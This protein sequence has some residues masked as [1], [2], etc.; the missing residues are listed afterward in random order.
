MRTNC[1]VCSSACIAPTNLKAPASAWRTSGALLSG[2]VAASGP[3]ANPARARPFTS[4]CPK[5]RKNKGA[6]MQVLHVLTHANNQ[7]CHP[8]WG[9][10]CSSSSKSLE[11]DGNDDERNSRDQRHICPGTYVGLQRSPERET[12]SKNSV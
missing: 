12:N 1:S 4:P 11:T 8:T 5:Q 3:K 9:S 10:S 6:R 7:M 2:T